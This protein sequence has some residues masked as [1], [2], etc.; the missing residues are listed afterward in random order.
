MLT[1][2]NASNIITRANACDAIATDPITLATLSVA[3]LAY[4]AKRYL[5]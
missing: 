4:V 5:F 2:L 3:L 1:C